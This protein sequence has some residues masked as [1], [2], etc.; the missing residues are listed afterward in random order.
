[1]K[2]NNNTIRLILWALMLSP[3]L[4][5]C[6]KFLDVVPDNV[7]TIENA[8]TM[9]KEAE[10]YL[11]T[12]YNYMPATGN[13]TGNP[14]FFAADEISLIWPYV[15]GSIQPASFRIARGFQNIV[16][17]YCNFWDGT[18]NGKDLF[19]G[20]RD[21]NIFLENIGKVPDIS[22]EERRRWI[23]EVKVMKAYY[24]FYLVRLYGPIPLIK[25]NLPID[26]GQDAVKVFRDPIDSCFNYIEQLMDEAREDLPE[27]LT[28]ETDELGRITRPIALALKARMLVT[29]ASP[30]F[31]G[32]A[33]YASY[34]DSRGIPLFNPNKDDNK[35]VKAAQAC[36]EAIELCHQVG[37]KLYTYKQNIQQ[38][39]LSPETVVQMSIRNALAEKWN[40]EI[41]WGNTNSMTS[42]LQILNLPR[43]LDATLSDNT[44]PRGQ[45]AP[46]IKMAE[47]FYT[48]NGLPINEDKTWDFAKR[49]TL[50]TGT[51]QEKYNIEEGYTT[52]ALHFDRENRF[53]ASMAFD[54]GKWY[55]QGKYDDDAIYTIKAKKGQAASQQVQ[56]SFSTTGYWIKKL[57]HFEDIISPTGSTLTIKDYP[58]PEFRLADL[59]LLYAEALNEK[60]GP[61]TEALDWINKVRER[62]AIPSVQDAWTNF[63]KT[64]GT[65]QTKEGLRRIIHQERSIELAFEGQRFYDLRRWK[66]ASEALN[67]PIAGWDIDQATPEAYYRVRTIFNQ[68]FTQKDYF[69]PIQESNI[70][71]NRNLLQSPGW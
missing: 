10:K 19:A 36:K 63:A 21:C 53:Y 7:A 40:T 3:F 9:R 28:N 26:A 67:T 54:G 52:A 20:L 60:D 4:G 71:V 12:C 55:G 6:K 18:Q 51:A 31:N 15:D 62:A 69:W 34:K 45:L 1:M 57:V 48:R 13:A 68:V 38:Y 2:L 5:S 17:P 30:L 39:D 8:F 37:L 23:A 56:F 32:N 44:A 35:W 24:H 64:P 27:L 22:E 50:R 29:A 49:F 47:M 58:W 70:T 42:A 16:A 46:T 65:F 33:D 25:E 59:Y 14:A 61:T 11:F 66:E 41:I 43:G